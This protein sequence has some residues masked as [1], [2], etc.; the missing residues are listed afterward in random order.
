MT[1]LAF[2]ARHTCDSPEWYTPSVFVDAAREVMG[3]ID[4]DPASHPEANET[5]R[6]VRFFTAEDDGLKQVWRGRIF[7]NPPGG[8][9]ANGKSLVP[10]FWRVLMREAC[11]AAVTG[12][13]FQA[14]WI[15]Y[16]LEQLQ[17]LR[18]SR[19]DHATQFPDVRA[20]AA[21]R[22]RGKRGKE[23]RASCQVDRGRQ[24][25]EPEITALARELHHLHRAE[26]WPIS[27]RVREVRCGAR[28]KWF[29]L[30]SVAV[31]SFGLIWWQ[32]RRERERLKARAVYHAG[33]AFRNGI[34]QTGVRNWPIEKEG[35]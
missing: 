32:H 2:A 34:D 12:E 26:L 18:A 7:L 9:D 17:T 3:G 13:C 20:E 21:D 1:N 23:S 11:E 8:K 22:V 25:A 27:S 33:A 19:H 4:L 14:L 6:A 35:W 10:Q 15:G 24:N 31:V 16:S 28:M 5:I 30:G 29:A